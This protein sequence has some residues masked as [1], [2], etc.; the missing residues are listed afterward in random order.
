MRFI[1][2][3]KFRRRLTKAETD[4]TDEILKANPQVKVISID[5][6][7]G[8]YDGVLVAEAPDEKTWMRFIDPM[9]EYIIS[10]TLVAIPRE[11]VLKIIEHSI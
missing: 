1:L 10:E 2:L 8:R 7:F 5:W 6:V 9:S 4:K 3:A 11:E